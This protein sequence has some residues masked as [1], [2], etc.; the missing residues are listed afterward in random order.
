MRHQLLSRLE[1]GAS[2]GTAT[3]LDE[4]LDLIFICCHPALPR[5]AEVA[6]TLRAVLGLTTEQIA[7]AFLVSEGTVAQRI[8][9]AKRKIVDAGIPMRVPSGDG[10]TSRLHEVLSVVYL[11]FNEGYLSSGPDAAAR[12]DLAAD[13]EWLASLPLGSLPD[14]PEVAGLLVLIRLHQAR[15]RSRF[16]QRGHL[17]LVQ[18]QD[19]T[20]WDQEAIEDASQLLTRALGQRRVGPF[21]VQAAIAACHATAPS[22]SETDW[23][24]DPGALRRAGAARPVPG[25]QAEPGDRAGR[26]GRTHQCPDRGRRPGGGA[27]RLPPL[28]RHSGRAAAKARPRGGSGGRRRGSGR[29]YQ[30][31]RRAAPSQAAHRQKALRVVPR[32]G[33]RPSGESE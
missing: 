17:V 14:E 8:V 22:W 10:L 1:I 27:G 24:E 12:L 25:G 28:P 3:V 2:M 18:D 9:R 19:R 23:K 13:T 31:P 4:R 26:S 11:M 33:G 5:E 32:G 21:Q 6:L 7:K 20:L 15:T 16:D 30:E 29:A